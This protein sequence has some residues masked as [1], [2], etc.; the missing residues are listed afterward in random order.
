MKLDDIAELIDGQ[1]IVNSADGSM[2]IVSVCSTDLMSDVL[3]F[4]TKGGI[5]GDCPEPVSGDQD[6]RNIGYPCCLDGPGKEDGKGDD[7][8]CH[9]KEHCI[10][11]DAFACVYRMRYAVC[12]GLR[13]CLED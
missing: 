6:C 12:R 3:R 2:D 13:S 5:A 10:D 4:A 8:A 1:I 7:R 11:G 9:G